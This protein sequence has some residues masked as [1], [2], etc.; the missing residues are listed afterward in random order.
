MPLFEPW[1]PDYIKRIAAGLSQI[2]T[3]GGKNLAH[4]PQTSGIHAGTTAGGTM[5]IMPITLR[6]QL[7]QSENI[8]M[9]IDPRVLALSQMS[10]SAITK[11]LNK[12]RNLDQAT[13]DQLL[14]FLLHKKQGDEAEVVEAHRRGLSGA[15]KTNDVQTMKDPYVRKYFNNLFDSL[16]QH[17]RELAQDPEK[18]M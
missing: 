2:E 18:L 8:G 6:D 7:R 1:S 17:P 13:Q 4:E 11:N 15:L 12:N 3:S 10:N 16:A 9:N 5:G 14:R